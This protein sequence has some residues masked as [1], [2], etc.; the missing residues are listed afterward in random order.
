[1]TPMSKPAGHVGEPTPTEVE[2]ELHTSIEGLQ[3]QVRALGAAI[4]HLCHALEATPGAVASTEVAVA[5]ED[6]RLALGEIW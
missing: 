3:V 5:L 4:D 6:A 1:M 2:L